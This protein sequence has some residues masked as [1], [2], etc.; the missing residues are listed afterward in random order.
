MSKETLAQKKSVKLQEFS[1][2]PINPKSLQSRVKKG[3]AKKVRALHSLACLVQS[4]LDSRGYFLAMKRATKERVF[5]AMKRASRSG[6][7]GKFNLK[8]RVKLR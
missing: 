6:I 5:L 2:G 1:Y 7:Q 4:T 3:S 8:L